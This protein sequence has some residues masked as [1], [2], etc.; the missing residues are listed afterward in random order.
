VVLGTHKGQITTSKDGI[1]ADQNIDFHEP[2][3]ALSLSPNG[4]FLGASSAL[5]SVSVWRLSDSSAKRVLR[6]PGSLWNP[7]SWIKWLTIFGSNTN[8]ITNALAIH[9]DEESSGYRQLGIMAAGQDDGRIKIVPVNGALIT[10]QKHSRFWIPGS[11]RGLLRFDSVRTVSFWRQVRGPGQCG[12][13]TSP[14]THPRGR[15]DRTP[16]LG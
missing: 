6:W 7:A 1:K 2:I 9:L 3:V 13:G 11:T 10:A 8:Q 16:A 15:M 4:E 5:W 14:E 12:S